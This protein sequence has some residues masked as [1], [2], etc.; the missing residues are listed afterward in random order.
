MIIIDWLHI[1]TIVGLVTMLAAIISIAFGDYKTVLAYEFPSRKVTV[2]IVDDEKRV[3]RS[4]LPVDQLNKVVV[5]TDMTILIK[6][7]DGCM[8][9]KFGGMWDDLEVDRSRVSL[10]GWL[11]LDGSV[12]VR[13][14]K[15]T[16]TV[17]LREVS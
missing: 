8:L 2:Q 13:N 16:F 4:V 3:I 17:I 6:Y 7:Y 11:P 10:D 12:Q 1:V 15:S 9:F 14:A 5:M